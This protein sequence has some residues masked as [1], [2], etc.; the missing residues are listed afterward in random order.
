MLNSTAGCTVH[1]ASSAWCSDVWSVSPI[2]KPLEHVDGAAAVAA[3]ARRRRLSCVAWGGLLYFRRGPCALAC[4]TT[5]EPAGKA[6]RHEARE[7][8]A[9]Q[10]R[11]ACGVVC[12]LRKG[13]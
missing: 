1:A 4:E 11:D 7:A 13:A 6:K 5:R 3:A 12:A 9:M 2:L 10:L 8:R